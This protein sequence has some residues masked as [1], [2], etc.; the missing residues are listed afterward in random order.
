MD[1]TIILAA[2]LVTLLGLVATI[3]GAESRDGFGSDTRITR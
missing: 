1:I 3:A 2:S